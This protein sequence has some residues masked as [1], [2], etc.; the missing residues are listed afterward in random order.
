MIEQTWYL[1]QQNQQ[2]GPFSQEQIQMMARANM[3]SHQAYVFKTGWKDWQPI[4]ELYSELGIERS[5]E[6]TQMN[7]IVDRR[8]TA[9]RATITGRVVIHNNVDMSIGQGVNI[10]AS[11]IFVETNGPIFQIGSVL[12]LSVRVDGLTQ[13]FNAMAEVVRYNDDP[14]FSVGY[15]LAFRGLDQRIAG[16]IQNLVD[17]LNVARG[18][19]SPAPAAGSS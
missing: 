3:I 16:Q 15:G 14:Q 7:A 12:K 1:Y 9:P 13:A 10:S 8:G 2:A 18:G 11:G 19:P 4:E 5:E 6:P 17:E